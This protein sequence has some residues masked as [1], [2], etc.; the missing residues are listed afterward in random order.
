MTGSASALKGKSTTPLVYTCF[1]TDIIH[2]GH[3][4]I[5]RECRKYGRVILGVMCDE[6][7]IH[8][9][10]FPTVSLEQRLENARRLENVEQVIV[11]HEI[12]YDK[13]FEKYKPDYV[14]HGDNWKTG[15]EQVIRKNV[16]SN[17]NLYG[18]N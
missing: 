18:E 16:I 5:L 3:R 7:M 14:V 13:I 2:E 17:L 12:M 15:P 10:R 6:A 8:F 9:N 11:Q 4:N 1:C